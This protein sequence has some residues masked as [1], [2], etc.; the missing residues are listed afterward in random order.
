MFNYFLDIDL[1]R[2]IKQITI[3]KD[4]RVCLFL[5]FILAGKMS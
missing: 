5:F 3:K 1:D 4:L 2:L